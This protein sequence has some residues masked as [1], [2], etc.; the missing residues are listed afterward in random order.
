MAKTSKNL[1]TAKIV[2]YFF[3]ESGKGLQEGTFIGTDDQG[4]TGNKAYLKALINQVDDVP[5]LIK[6][7][8]KMRGIELAKE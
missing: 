6:Q 7:Y 4:R 5:A 8:L 2:L 3:R 1:K